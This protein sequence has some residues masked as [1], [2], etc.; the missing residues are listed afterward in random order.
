M[1]WVRFELAAGKSL[2]SMRTIYASYV[3]RPGTKVYSVLEARSMCRDF[4]RTC[5]KVC[6]AP[7]DLLLGQGRRAIRF[8]GAAHRT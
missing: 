3:E 2:T 4:E 8:P 5:I 6:A 7:G 1:L